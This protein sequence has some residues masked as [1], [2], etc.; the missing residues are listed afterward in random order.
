[1]SFLFK[2]HK[3]NFKRVVNL[4]TNRNKNIL[5][6]NNVLKQTIFAYKFEKI[7]IKIDYFELMCYN[8]IR[9]VI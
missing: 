8:F 9:E 4:P 6:G 3:D 2:V 7:N 1:M 5:K